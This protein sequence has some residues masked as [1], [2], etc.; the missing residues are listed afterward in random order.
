MILR[1][2]KWHFSWYGWDVFFYHIDFELYFYLI[3]NRVGVIGCLASTGTKPTIIPC[4]KGGFR[5]YAPHRL[6]PVGSAKHCFLGH[7]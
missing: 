2:I 1:Q 7:N 5:I 4:K 6:A 3:N